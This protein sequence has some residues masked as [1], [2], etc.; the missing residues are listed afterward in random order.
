MLF[1]YHG[2]FSSKYRILSTYPFILNCSMKFS[3]KI[4][5]T[6]QRDCF[7]NLPKEWIAQ[8]ASSGAKLVSSEELSGHI[9]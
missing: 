5:F 8:L 3:G 6:S 2:L 1:L 9:D 4:K 7:A